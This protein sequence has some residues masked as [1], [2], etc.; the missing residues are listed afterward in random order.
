MLRNTAASCSST[1]RKRRKRPTRMKK[2][3][4]TRKKK[5]KKTKAKKPPDLHAT[6]KFTRRNHQQGVMQTYQRDHSSNNIA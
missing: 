2:K 1:A 3:K 6:H 4:K 5:K